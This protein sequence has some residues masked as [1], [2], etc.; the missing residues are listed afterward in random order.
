MEKTLERLS[1]EIDAAMKKNDYKTVTE[2]AREILMRPYEEVG[3]DAFVRASVIFAYALL[4]LGQTDDAGNVLKSLLKSGLGAVD[5]HYLLFCIAYERRNLAEIVDHGKKFIELIREKEKQPESIT[6]AVQ[7]A[8]ELINNLATA[9]LEDGQYEDAVEVLNTGIRLKPDYN[10]FYV[11]LGIACHR[12]DNFEEA[13]NIL[14]EGLKKCDDGGEIHRTLGLVYDEKYYYLNAEIQLKKAVE[15]GVFE[16]LLDLGMLYYKLYKIYDAEEEL[17]NYLKYNP[18]ETNATNLLYDLRSLEF[19]GKPEQTISAA[20]IVKNEENMLGECIE[21]FREAVDEIVVVDTGSTDRTVEIAESYHVKVYHH[22]WKDDFSEARNFSIGKA[23]GDWVLVIDAD[24]R[25]E[26]EDIPKVRS[27]KWQDKYDAVCFAVYSSLPGQMGNANFGKHYSP[28]LFRKRKDIYYYGI[29]HNLLQV[30]DE[31]YVTGIRLY[32]LGYD[33]DQTRMKKK[34]QRSLELLLKQVE[35]QPDDPFVLLNVAQM[36]LSRNYTKEA[37]EYALRCVRLLEDNPGSQEH[38]LLMG[39]YQLSIIYL[40]RRDFEKC[41]EFAHRALKIKDNYIDPMLN[42]GWCYYNLKK[43]DKAVEILEKYLTTLRELMENEE[44]NLIIL[45][46]L[47]S[48]YEAH[49]LL[50]EI[51]KERGDF[52]AAKRFKKALESNYYYWNIHH[53]LGKIYLQEGKYAEAADAFENAVKYGYLNREKYGTIGAPNELYREAVE[54]YKLAVEKD[55]RAKKSPP[56]VKDALG[57]IDA[58]LESS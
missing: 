10:L 24:E 41:E 9:L 28:R 5:S 34:F 27:M 54:D 17:Q 21:S 39:L 40:R 13:E 14:L 55:V 50:G 44:F 33:L 3:A 4:K 47:G 51:C 7:N 57:N 2:C 20:M 58:L 45:N 23:T 11:N 52:D 19:Y 31:V 16:A 30:P 49:Y 32:H 22:K 8:H 43:Y 36:Y 48:D 25:L 18:G 53:G 42:L 6:T 46:K 12:Q 37:E 26:R 35:E 29:V 38:L 1:Q 56:D 15:K